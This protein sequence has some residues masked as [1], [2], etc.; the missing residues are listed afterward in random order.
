MKEAGGD[1]RK[2]PLP[3]S[4]SQIKIR[5][6]ARAGFG[7]PKPHP[8]GCTRCAGRRRGAQSAAVQLKYVPHC[9]PRRMVGT[10]WR[11]E[12]GVN[13][14]MSDTRAG[15]TRCTA[16]ESPEAHNNRSKIQ[17]K[18][19]NRYGVGKETEPAALLQTPA[20]CTICIIDCSFVHFLQEDNALP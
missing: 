12:C 16:R 13:D 17:K 5:H 20:H 6:L 15:K 10:L 8:S 11:D 1:R 2:W 4:E 19:P 18:R 14:A 9:E 3:S 7:H